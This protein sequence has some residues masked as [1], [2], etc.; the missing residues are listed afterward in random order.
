VADAPDAP[1]APLALL[2]YTQRF[3]K[4]EQPC[5]ER[6]GAVITGE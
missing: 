5:F 3:L 6:E 4:S 2:A 1:V